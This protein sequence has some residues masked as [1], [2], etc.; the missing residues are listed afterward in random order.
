[1]A[2]QNPFLFA[3]FLVSIDFIVCMCHCKDL[4]EENVKIMV[5]AKALLERKVSN[6]EVNGIFQA[7]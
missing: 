7:F 1:M 3:V 6:G 5:Y 2:C 4:S